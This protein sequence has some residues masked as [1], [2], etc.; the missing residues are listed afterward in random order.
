MLYV[1]LIAYDN[2]KSCSAV[3][4]W[5]FSR[6]DRAFV[7]PA[8]LWFIFICVRRQGGLDSMLEHLC[9]FTACWHV[10]ACRQWRLLCCRSSSTATTTA[11]AAATTAAASTLCSIHIC[12]DALSTVAKD[13]GLECLWLSHIHPPPKLSAALCL[14]PSEPGSTLPP[15]QVFFTWTSPA[16]KAPQPDSWLPSSC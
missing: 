1:F 11:A 10:S 8:I 4:N 3:I 7:M 6:H 14:K 12:P 13:P 15:A 2:K 5:L 16:V 9:T